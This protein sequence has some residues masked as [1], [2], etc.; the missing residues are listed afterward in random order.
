MRPVLYPS[1]LLTALFHRQKVVTMNDMKHALGTSVS[2]TV[3][4]KLKEIPYRTSYSHS[5]MFYVLEQ[6]MDFDTRGLWSCRGAHFSCFG[7]L[8]DTAEKFVARSEAGF[9]A[10]ELTKELGVE[11]REPLRQLARSRR[12]GREEVSSLYLYCSSDPAQRRQQLLKRQLPGTSETAGTVLLDP[13]SLT[14]DQT[15]TVL[16]LFF[17]LLNQKQRRLFGGLESLRLGRGGDRLMSALTGLDVHTIARGR[18][19]LLE[20]ET[21]L[22][23]VRKP[24]GGRLLLEKKRQTSSSNWKT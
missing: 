15:R 19:E 11:T 21:L 17:N 8:L 7:S 9:F 12:L 13:A 23:Q 2:M 6:N 18:R 4:R 10:F 16:L 3:F 14:T 1:S 5:G 24:G 22:D 20:R